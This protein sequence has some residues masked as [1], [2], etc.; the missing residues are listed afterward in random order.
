[1]NELKEARVIAASQ[2]D[3]WRRSAID[4]ESQ[5]RT[6]PNFALIVMLSPVGCKY[7]G[8]IA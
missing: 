7:R 8:I 6:K 1:M 5:R 3:A 4:V 2:D